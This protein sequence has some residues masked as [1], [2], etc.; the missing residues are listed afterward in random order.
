MDLRTSSFVMFFCVCFFLFA[1][2]EKGLVPGPIVLVKYFELIHR[3][4]LHPC[5]FAL[6]YFAKERQL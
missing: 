4:V 6:K 1:L 3:S 5:V 2:A